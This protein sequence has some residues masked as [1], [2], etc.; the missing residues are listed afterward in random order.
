MSLVV[1]RSRALVAVW[2]RRPPG[3]AVFTRCEKKDGRLD[4]V[5]RADRVAQCP[6]ARAL[7]RHRPDVQQRGE[8]AVGKPVRA[9]RAVA[10]IAR[11]SAPEPRVILAVQRAGARSTTL[12]RCALAV[13][14]DNPRFPQ[15]TERPRPI[16]TLP[17]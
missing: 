5:K 13:A 8:T 11:H 10:L 16:E 2:A 7:R 14:G 4:L 15:T 3:V 6:R 1:S 17:G 9:R 12:C